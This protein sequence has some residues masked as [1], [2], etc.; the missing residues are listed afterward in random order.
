LRELRE[1][2]AIDCET[3][4]HR[5]GKAGAISTKVALL[6]C[7]NGRLHRQGVSAGGDMAGSE[8]RRSGERVTEHLPGIFQG[9]MAA[10]PGGRLLP[11]VHLRWEHFFHRSLP[12][13]AEGACQRCR[14]CPYSNSL[15]NREAFPIRGSQGVGQDATAQGRQVDLR[16]PFNSAE[17]A[18]TW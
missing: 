4:G 5:G 13:P 7:L 8:Y 2:P 1:N 10:T 16:R 11:G 14:P 12:S 15:A 17:T 3:S 6:Q 18:G 9:L